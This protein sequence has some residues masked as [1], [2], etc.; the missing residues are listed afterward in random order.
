MFSTERVSVHI[1]CA[2]FWV[3]V[4]MGGRT[5]G[6][7]MDFMAAKRGPRS[8]PLSEELLALGFMPS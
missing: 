5:A 7:V 2:R 6:D 1:C 3:A 4:R 8:S